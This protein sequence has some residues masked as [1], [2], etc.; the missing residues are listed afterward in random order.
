MLG[1]C[2]QHSALCNRLINQ[3]FDEATLDQHASAFDNPDYVEVVIHSYRHRLGLAAGYPMYEEF[4]QRL[5]AQPTITV[6]TITLDGDADGVVPA[7]DGKSTAAKF[8]GERQH[9]VI[10]NVGH[11]L[12]QEDPKA[13]ATAVWELASKKR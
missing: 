5:A 8:S 2:L 4:E 1:G 3:S 9:R 7:T 10:P 11:N 6:P 12:P 13:F